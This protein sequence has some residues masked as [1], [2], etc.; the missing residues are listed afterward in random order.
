MLAMLNNEICSIRPGRVIPLA[1]LLVD[2][3]AYN[4]LRRVA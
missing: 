1:E 2:D 3:F 4:L